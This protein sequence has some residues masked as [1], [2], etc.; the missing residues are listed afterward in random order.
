MI[1]G[2]M[3]MENGAD[4]WAS[5]DSNVYSKGS[6]TYT[7]AYAFIVQCLSTRETSALKP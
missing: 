2:L 4:D 6:F 5:S 1:T 3:D 7:P